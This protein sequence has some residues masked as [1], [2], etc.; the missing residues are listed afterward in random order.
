M[1]VKYRTSSMILSITFSKVHAQ[2]TRNCNTHLIMY[3]HFGIKVSFNMIIRAIITHAPRKSPPTFV[4]P[5]FGRQLRPSRTER[6]GAGRFDRE[7]RPQV[8][9]EKLEAGI[10]SRRVS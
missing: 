4:R 5:Q 7:F 9:S 6:L 10:T 1:R 8:D 3:V 2:P